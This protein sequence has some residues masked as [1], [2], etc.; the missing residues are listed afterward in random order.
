MRRPQQP[1][2]GARSPI[3]LMIKTPHQEMEPNCQKLAW[4]TYVHNLSLGS[5][6]AA[7]TDPASDKANGFGSSKSDTDATQKDAATADLTVKADV[8]ME[9]MWNTK[10]PSMILPLVIPKMVSGQ[11]HLAQYV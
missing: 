1:V 5:S 3:S 6:P 11:V 7:L 9:N 10:Y 8:K 2:L 4:T